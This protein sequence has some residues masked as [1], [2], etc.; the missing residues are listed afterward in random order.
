MNPTF[1]LPRRGILQAAGALALAGIGTARAQDRSLRIGLAAPPTTLDP[2]FQSNAPNNSVATHIYD[3]LVVNDERSQTVPGL[4]ESWKALD[5]THW[6]FK[7]R[8]G[9]KFSDGTPFVAEDAIVSFNRAATLPSTASF[10]TY[11]RSIKSMRAVDDHTLHIETKAPDALLPNSVSRIRIIK[12]ALKD[13][14]TS[15][16]NSG[17]AAIGTGPYKLVEYVPGNQVS[18]TRNELYWGDR[19]AWEK[20]SLRVMSSPPARTAA[21]LAGDV[22]LIE[23]V[24]SDGLARIKADPKLHVIEG[25]SNR[26]IYVGLD[27]GRESSPFITDASG[28]PL[29][30]NPLQDIRVRQALSLAINQKA[31]VERVME[32]QALPAAQF[33][34]KGR[35]GTSDSLEDAGYDPARAKALLAE[36]GYPQGFRMTVHGPSDRYINDGKIVQALAQMFT[37]IGI[38][39]KAEPTPWTVYSAKLGEPYYSVFV[40]G[41]GANT[42]ETSNPMAALL[43]TW[44][45]AAGLGVSNNGRYSNAEF[46]ALLKKAMRTMDNKER[47]QMLARA[48]EMVIKDFG[49]IPLHHEI[50]LWGARKDI[51]Y[52]ARADQYTLAMEATPA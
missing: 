5:D 38:E 41:W 13:A 32:G 26:M 23:H 7:L 19:P 43:A 51:N 8:P 3:T 35:F 45:K 25:V 44:D 21:L 17:Q 2:H 15:D 22:D 16:F 40:G 31:I 37:R 10:R 30:K 1:T 52:T 39:T 14:S 20:V 6:E 49:L 28:T 18:L 50:S 36:A 12:H 11:T 48:S 27:T 47:G 34:P 24:P 4:A 33:L 46:D 42:G 9:V 29:P